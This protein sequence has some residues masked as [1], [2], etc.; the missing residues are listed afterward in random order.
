MQDKERHNTDVLKVENSQ[1]RLFGQR[2][3]N[4][5]HAHNRE[6]GKSIDGVDAWLASCAKQDAENLADYCMADMP[7]GSV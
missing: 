5:L 2:V 1:K 7:F 4:G 6:V 3:V